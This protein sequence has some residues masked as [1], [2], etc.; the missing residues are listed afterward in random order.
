M[1]LKAKFFSSKKISH[2]RKMDTEHSVHKFPITEKDRNKVWAFCA[3]QT[4]DDF[5]GNP[6][7]LFIY[8]NKYRND[9]TA[10]WLCKSEETMEFVRNLGYK[11]Y[12]EDTLEGQEALARTGV[13]VA[14]QAKNFL[15]AALKD[16]KY[17]NLYHGIGGKQVE[18]DLTEGL[19]AVTL[20]KKY[21]TNNSFYRDR[22]L[23][24]ATSPITQKNFE[25]MC[26]I[27]SDKIV[28]GG[29]PRC[30]Y[31]KHFDRIET[32]DHDILAK[33]GLPPDTR[34]AVYA[35]TFRKDSKDSIFTT[36][37][38]DL[39]RLV[40]ACKKYRYLMVF[41][42]HPIME[43][44][45]Q[46]LLA[47]ET[48]KDCPYLYFWDNKDDF[49]EIIDKVDLGIV[50]YSSI[51][52]DMLDAGVTH[53]I[54]Y[55]YDFEDYKQNL[56][57]PYD[58]ITA[59]IK[60]TSFDELLS[61]MANYSST[62]VPKE[63]LKP[64]H[65]RFW[66]YS[67][68]D[69]LENMVNQT[70]KFTPIDRVRK[71]LYSFD[72]F[73][74]LISRKVVAPEG[75]F[76]YVK[77]KMRRSDLHF[78]I[79]L[80]DRYPELRQ[81]CESNARE[82]YAK[83]QDTRR[84]LRK[85]IQFYEIFERM[86]ELYDLNDEQVELLKQWELEAELE[87]AIPVT[88]NVKRC[89]NL[90]HSGETVVLI[91]DMYLPKEFIQRML[92]KVSSELAELPIYLSS[93]RGWQKTTSMLYLEVYKDFGAA[94]D[95]DRWIHT[96]DNPVADQKMAR[97]LGIITKP[98]TPITFNEYE[99]DLVKQ[100]GTYDAYLI[101]GNM[102]RFRQT[103][104]QIREQ[105]A[106]EYISLYMVPY[107]DWAI[108]EAVKRGDQT[109]Y[110][111]SRDGY[112]LK[113]IADAIVRKENLVLKT[114][115]IY[116]SRRTWRVPS[117]INEIDE[118]FWG[119]FGNF[120]GVDTFN[121]LLRA[122]GMDETTFR[123]MFPELQALNQ[124]TI[125]DREYI[126]QL[127]EIFKQSDAY[128]KYVLDLAK[129][130]RVSVC[131]YL[132]Q[133]IAQDEQFSIIEYWGRGYTQDCFVRLWNHITGK[134][135]DISFY[136]ARTILPTQ[137]HSVRYNFTSN[138]TSQIFVEAIFANLNYKSV[139][140]YH[141]EGNR[142]EP[143]LVP[144]DCDEVLLQAMEDCLPTFTE[145]YLDCDFV[146]R[147]SLRRELFDFSLSYYAN[148]QTNE[149]FL[150]IVAPLVDSVD[151]YGQK[152]EFAKTFTMKDLQSFEEG[153]KRG[154]LTHNIPMSV[155]R[156]NELVQ[157]KYR[158]LYQILPGEPLNS[159]GILTKEEI[160]NN[161]EYQK[162]Y[163]EENTFAQVLA[164]RYEAYAQA[165]QTG[166][167]VVIC[168]KGN[169]VKKTVFR[170]LYNLLIE[171]SG[172]NTQLISFGSATFDMEQAAKTMSQASYIIVAQNLGEIAYLR[173]RPETKVIQLGEAAFNFL[174][175]NK[176]KLKH[177]Q[178]LA[179]FR[180]ERKIN[181]MQVPSESMIPVFKEHYSLDSSVDFSLKGCC[182]TDLYFDA[183]ACSK[184]RELVFTAE[185][186]AR[187]KK[188]IFYM[189]YF[190][191][192]SKESKYMEFLDLSVLQEALG[193]E[194]FVI[195]NL[196]PKAKDS[197]N[198]VEI[199]G[200]A[201]NVTKKMYLREA[202]A[203]ADIVIGDYRDALFEATLIDKPVF[204]TSSDKNAISKKTTYF[205]YEDII[206]GVEVQSEEDLIAKIRAI[207]HYD[208]TNSRIFREKYLT[209]CDGKS[210]NR[211]YDY[212]KS[213]LGK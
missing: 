28:K 66:A 203:A 122:L 65:E 141:L 164:E 188:I 130:G 15:P 116:A 85:E 88:E 38:P 42:M 142:Y 198:I 182:Q 50:D 25:K 110:F 111:I 205:D 18:R 112:H 19:L 213:N 6:K 190:R 52:T 103:H 59:G 58:E 193:D 109:V 133:E 47:K 27:D 201:V 126:L 156:S 21:I 75:I 183:N 127:A 5:R 178:I 7:Y 91:S 140:S 39:D 117:F 187:D 148:N 61:A 119:S 62:E 92:A 43:D 172:I 31:Q 35:P 186:K 154:Q 171:D 118:E 56:T 37:F 1:S 138:H 95:F 44:D 16:A 57:D 73:D 84:A 78:P 139:E 134:E 68:K 197:S 147:A 166:N 120:S 77:E 4:S 161:Q 96:G 34:L 82:Y 143:N 20:A 67:D 196:S 180:R 144:I 76:Y 155:A 63:I 131:G 128:R 105:F 189:P 199:P 169:L 100:L 114:K 170:K 94:Y 115:Y 175:Q 104:D 108:H 179:D 69:S 200:F 132:K 207:E 36:A 208:Y 152:R 55:V 3:G 136:Y 204:I 80:I 74:T 33:K 176:F 149:M 89:L 83:T 184:A 71:N 26:G 167:T 9:I 29:Y 162:Q 2:R 87:N 195:M 79:H 158:E 10:Y 113:R 165:T 40:D 129:N 124:E 22:Q 192:R 49:Y 194:Y 8:I 23:F 163:H 24:L 60:C 13:L 106:Y 17:L 146:D 185:P 93:E 145:D 174:S 153:T 211:V 177:R 51:F 11:A 46:Y 191:Y 107:I 90:C 168:G 30:V 99:S 157:K 53:Y 212:I 137:G 202:I 102:A 12:C 14:E 123:K 45:S 97:K 101:A 121:K 48:Y 70:L 32:F 81:N 210:S 125:F 72:I 86:G 135:E 98:V 206:P 159:G 209:Y 54:R 151:L 160:G 41:K 173:V 64:I 181:M 150:D